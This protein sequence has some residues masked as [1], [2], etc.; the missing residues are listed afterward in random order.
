M[1]F[2]I[3]YQSVLLILLGVSLP[4][5][6]AFGQD[7]YTII[8]LGTLGGSSSS[9]LGINDS[10][11][12]VGYSFTSG[13]QTRATLF[14]GTG[15]NNT[16]LGTFGGSSYASGINNSGQ[17]IGYAF[18]GTGILHATFYSGVGSNNT[19]LGTLG[20][21]YSWAYGIND[22]GQMVGYSWNSGG[23]SH[24]TL[25]SGTGSGNTDLGTLGGSSSYAYGINDAGQT[26]GY[27]TTSGGLSH[28]TLFSITDGNNT[29]L[30]T[31]GG[32]SSIAYGIND[33]GQIVGNSYI[34]GDSTRHATLFSI[35][36]SANIDLGTLGGTASSASAINNLGQIV[37]FSNTSGNVANHGFLYS[38]GSM[39]DLNDLAAYSAAALGVTGINL[40]SGSIINDWG[41]IAA[42]GNVDGQGTRALLL[43][44][45][46]PN[47][48]SGRNAES[49]PTSNTKLV[50][51]MIYDKVAGVSTLGSTPGGGTGV[52]LLHGAAGSGGAGEFGLNRDVNL[53]VTGGDGE[54]YGN[55]VELTGTEN[56]TFTI[57]LFY[58]QPDLIAH[59]GSEEN[60]L[61][62]W[63]NEEGM[64]VNAVEGN[65]GGTAA[66][67]DG[68]PDSSY[69]LGSYGIDT[70]NNSVWAVINHNSVFG[71][72][73][74]PEPSS[75]LL[76]GLLGISSSLRRRRS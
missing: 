67:I 24:A 58:E 50:A 27:S 44:P 62:G 10:G 56:D 49:L 11:Q 66:L 43:N 29:N 20:G 64:W 38:D 17:I 54:A 3:R 63:L 13:G 74:V 35:T 47:R 55:L 14:S 9:A 19:D 76:A 41:Q 72:I 28:A 6:A 45:V 23:Q 36:G 39:K 7:E 59:F 68:G 12:I 70:D 5:S 2:S 32:S 61:L 21:S 16:D 57:R 60:I 52:E 30:G 73:Q 8:N 4:T 65:N 25:F 48:A 31:L 33:I 34:S 75:L 46:N 71:I 53:S 42:Y 37:G 51:G 26:V 1:K 69:A 40:N 18:D 22:V 15:S